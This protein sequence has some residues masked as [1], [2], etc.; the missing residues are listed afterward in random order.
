MEHTRIFRSVL[1]PCRT[2]RIIPKSQDH[3]D[4]AQPSNEAEYDSDEINANG[5][6]N[7]SKL[8]IVDVSQLVE[9]AGW[10]LGRNYYVV[11]KGSDVGVF[12]QMSVLIILLSLYFSYYIK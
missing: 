8:F 3:S 2:A 9:P 7:H 1:S 5:V 6:M 4:N 12:H 11:M 10:Y